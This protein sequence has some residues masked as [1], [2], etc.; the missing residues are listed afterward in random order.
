MSDPAFE[1]G[2]A[3]VRGGRSIHADY[4]LWDV[5]RQ[6]N[7]DRGRQFGVLRPRTIPLWRDGALNPEAVAWFKRT[8]M[9]FCEDKAR[10]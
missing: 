9:S 1:F 4:V 5:D 10:L 7:F 6:W 2:V 8:A 3:D